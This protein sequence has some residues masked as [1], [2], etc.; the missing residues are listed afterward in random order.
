MP[1]PSKDFTPIRDDYEFFAENSTEA[2]ADLDAY[3]ER[4]R[5]FDPPAGTTRMLDFGCGPGSFTARFPDRLGWGGDRLDPALVEPTAAY[6]Q[7]AVER[8]GAMTDRPIRAWDALPAGSE[9]AFDLI[10]SHHVLYYVPE[11]RATLDG[12]VRALDHR[13]LFLTAIAGRDNALVDLWFGGFPL[14]GRPVPYHT[15]VDVEE[16]LTGLGVAFDRRGRL[17]VELPGHGGGPAEDPPLPL[18]RAPGGPA[19]GRT[20]GLLRTVRVGGSGR[21][22]DGQRAV[23]R[24][25][26]IVTIPAQADGD[27]MAKKKKP[28]SSFL[29]RWHIVLMSAWDEEYLNE[30]VQAFIEFEGGEKGE[31]QFGYVRGIMDYREGTRDGQPAVEFSWEGGDGADGTPLTGRGWAILRESELHGMIFIHL[32]DESEFVAERAGGAAKKL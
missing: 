8:L 29:G 30:E 15:A 19:E 25:G 4:L 21:H 26:R 28:K 3:A 17:R 13:G 12:L 27:T 24:E 1:D 20:A 10:L 2:T 14:I 6:R 22:A 18:R 9:R 5:S 16:A 23:L 31:F 11:L 32:G 7:Q